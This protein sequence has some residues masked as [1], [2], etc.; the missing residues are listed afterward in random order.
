[1][2][3]SCPISA[4]VGAEEARTV[5]ARADEPVERPDSG[6]RPAAAAGFAAPPRAVVPLAVVLLAVPFVD[7]SRA[8][9]P[10]RGFASAARF[11][12]DVVPPAPADF[13]PPDFFAASALRFFA[14]V[15]AA[16]VLVADF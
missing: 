6:G 10:P 13:A 9:L 4:A 5:D 7:A 16:I 14:V 1:M 8:L 3:R 12:P 11:A 15:L 2:T